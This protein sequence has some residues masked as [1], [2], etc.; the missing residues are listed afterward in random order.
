MILNGRYHLL[1]CSKQDVNE[2]QEP[3]SYNKT[4]LELQTVCRLKDHKMKYDLHNL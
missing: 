1:I 4:V 2:L 3:P